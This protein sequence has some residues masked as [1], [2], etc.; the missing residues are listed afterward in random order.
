MRKGSSQTK[1]R[2]VIL[3]YLG[4]VLLVIGGIGIMWGYGRGRGGAALA[5]ALMLQGLG[6]IVTG[7]IVMFR[8][9]SADVFYGKKA[10]DFGI[11]TFALGLFF[12]VVWLYYFV[13]S[14]V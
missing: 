2:F 12:L 6:G 8:P 13:L 10:Q 1:W 7:R 9:V 4:L 11:L 3:A 5:M 14:P